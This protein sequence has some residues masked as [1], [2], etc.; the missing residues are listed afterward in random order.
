[1][2]TGYTAKLCE[3]EQAFEEF[4][5][6]C[7]RAFG[8]TIEL[9]DEPLSSEIP[10]FTPSTYAQDQAVKAENELQD[11]YNLTNQER[12][13]SFAAHVKAETARYVESIEDGEKTKIRLQAM[14]ANVNKW[15][16]PSADH[17]EFKRFMKAQ[18]EQAIGFDANTDWQKNALRELS[19]LEFESWKNKKIETLKERIED[20]KNDQTQ[21]NERTKQRNLWVSRLR[22]SLA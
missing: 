13:N 4:A 1:M 7:A 10:E 6:T 19:L 18:L 9:R 8:A 22:A 3:G 12:E 15:E 16:S 5:L 20:R 2:P 21:E 14:L 17:D 11:F